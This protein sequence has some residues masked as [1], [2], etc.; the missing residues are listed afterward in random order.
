MLFL[1]INSINVDSKIFSNNLEKIGKTEIGLISS[2]DLGEEIFGI[3]IGYTTLN[4][5]GK[6][7]A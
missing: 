7:I 1:L 2:S 6:K 3:G 4:E 5:L